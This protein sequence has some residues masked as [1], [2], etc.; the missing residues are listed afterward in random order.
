[1][2]DTPKLKAAFDAEMSKPLTI[3]E[4]V[5]VSLTLLEQAIN[6]GDPARKLEIRMRDILE[7]VQEAREEYELD[8]TRTD[9]NIAR[10]RIAEL[11]EGLHWRPII[12]AP[13]DGTHIL[14]CD[15]SMPYSATWTFNQ[16]P[17]TVVHYWDGMGAPDAGFYTSV[18]ELAPENTFP[19]THWRPLGP[20]PE[21]ASPESEATPEPDAGKDKRIAELEEGLHWRPIITAPRDGTH[22]LACDASMPYSATWTFNQRPP[23]VVHYWDGMGAPDAGFYTS[24]NELAP[25]NT[26]PAT[27]WRPLGPMPEPASPESEATPEP[28]AGKDKRI[29]ELEDSHRNLCVRVAMLEMVVSDLLDELIR[30]GSADRVLQ[31]IRGFLPCNNDLGNAG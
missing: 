20:M 9:R 23:T 12:T 13:R 30:I 25:E 22:I 16:R 4:N 29:A 2:T 15:A 26:F 28:D 8:D 24:V 10:Q 31:Q 6:E 11:E 7:E 18:N 3:L 1:M 19:A 21:P 14:A 17:P 27:H 5:V